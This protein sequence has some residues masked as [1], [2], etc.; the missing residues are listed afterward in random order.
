MKNTARSGEM[1]DRESYVVAKA[2]F[3]AGEKLGLTQGTLADV[4]GISK[5]QMS[6]VAKGES[7][8]TG[9]NRELAEYLI[10]VFRSL[11][12]MTGGDE[13]LGKQWMS[14]RN[15]DLGGARPIELIE[16]AAG[17]VD[18]MNYLDAARAPI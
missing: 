9:K 4:A 1:N 15:T 12:A 6:R 18:V 2:F 17:L 8:I 7:P 16:N 13:I 14:S 11:D 5:S 10:R 3:R